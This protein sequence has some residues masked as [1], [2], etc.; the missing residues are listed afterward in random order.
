VVAGEAALA[1][2]A[3]GAVAV[4]VGAAAVAEAALV[5]AAGAGAV[6]AGGAA[7]DCRRFGSLTR[8]L[9]PSAGTIS[10][11]TDTHRRGASFSHQPPDAIAT[12]ST[13]PT[14]GSTHIAHVPVEVRQPKH[15][16]GALTA[17]SCAQSSNRTT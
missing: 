6:V 3:V 5:V 15:K 12:I 1:G 8:R 14:N 9:P 10:S 2:A 7:S 16:V 4:A 13:P 11:S 17:H